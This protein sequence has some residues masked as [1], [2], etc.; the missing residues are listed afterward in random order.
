MTTRP[1]FRRV[2]LPALLSL[3][4]GY[5]VMPALSIV[6]VDAR[7][8]GTEHASPWRTRANGIAAAVASTLALALTFLGRLHRRL[9][10]MSRSPLFRPAVALAMLALVALVDHKALFAAPFIF[11]ATA[12]EGQHAGE[13]LLEERMEAGRPSRENITVLSGQNLKAGAV[14]GRVNKAAGRV[15]TP[16]VVGTGNGTVSL[17]FAGPEVELGNYVLTCTAA[18]ANGGVFSL[19]TPSGKAMVPLTM[20]PGGGGTT[21]YASRHLNFSITDGATDFI[22]TDAFTFVVSTTAPVAIGTGNGTIS[23]LSLGPDAKTGNY[24]VECIAAIT[25]SGTFKVADPGGAIVA[26]GTIVAGAG[27]TLVLAGQRQLNL[28][29]TDG[30][31]DFAVGDAFNVTVYNNLAGGKVVAWDPLTFDGRSISVGALYDNVDATL[32]DTAGVIIT[33]DA[34]VDRAG[35]QYTAGLSAADKSGAENDLGKRNIIVR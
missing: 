28:T 7:G 13:F 24:R 27:G 12:S 16:V 9:E 20:T 32:A 22:V 6:R 26:V 23:G 5:L 34:T 18:V 33:R 25:N 31:T 4:V 10:Q 11:G 35:L 29:V 8:M 30:A 21:V 17:V 2:F 1:L 15:S 19:T 14:I 3:L